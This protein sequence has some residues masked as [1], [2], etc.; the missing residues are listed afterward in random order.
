MTN[1]EVRGPLSGGPVLTPQQQLVLDALGTGTLLVSEVQEL[2]GLGYSSAGT[3]LAELR[4]LGLVEDLPK[5][6][7]KEKARW[8][9][10]P[11][12]RQVEVRKKVQKA[13]RKALLN[14][15]LSQPAGVQG[16]VFTAAIRRERNKGDDTV[17]PVTL[18][19]WC[20]APERKE[21]RE[22]G[23][24]RVRAEATRWR[25]EQSL[26]PQPRDHY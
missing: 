3:R 2:T 22:K 1:D 26:H 17:D 15:L 25:R 16:Y 8:R 18:Y 11:P 13:H 6:N 23:L 9:A 19:E 24:S 7:S 20:I 5:P 12:A 10:V 21:S 4:R 14:L